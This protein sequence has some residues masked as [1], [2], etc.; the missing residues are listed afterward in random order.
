[1]RIKESETSTTKKP[2]TTSTPQG[3][4]T[5]SY[6]NA[7][8]Y[9]KPADGKS[10]NINTR[11][12]LRSYDPSLFVLVHQIFPCANNFAGRCHSRSKKG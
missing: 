2:Q 10:N 8:S 4:G 1:M 11:V 3:E 9:A 6:Y 5:Q 7:N 12:K